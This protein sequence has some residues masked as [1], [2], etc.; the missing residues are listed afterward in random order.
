M[1]TAPKLASLRAAADRYRRL[2][3]GADPDYKGE[4]EKSQDIFG[5]TVEPGPEGTRKAAYDIKRLM[6]VDER[7]LIEHA[8]ALLLD[9]PV[10]PYG[11]PLPP[12][13]TWSPDY[14]QT[15][16][17]THPDGW[18]W[19]CCVIAPGGPSGTRRLVVG[20]GLYA[21]EAWVNLAAR[22]WEEFRKDTAPALPAFQPSRVENAGAGFLPPEQLGEVIPGECAPPPAPPASTN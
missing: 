13:Y 21:A 4:L 3:K 6:I 14:D 16:L 8:N 18:V 17:D 1:P 10:G 20:R 22:A 11:I 5:V 12:G 2:H 15:P 7:A 9:P 19:T